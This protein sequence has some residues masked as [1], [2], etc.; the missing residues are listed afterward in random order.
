MSKCL[1][2]NVHPC[3]TFKCTLR[4]NNSDRGDKKEAQINLCCLLLMK[5]TIVEFASHSSRDPSFYPFRVMI[6]DNAKKEKCS[7]H[8]HIFSCDI[9]ET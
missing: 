3:L 6:V 1:L 7:I 4:K 8:P 5:K 9:P 2:F